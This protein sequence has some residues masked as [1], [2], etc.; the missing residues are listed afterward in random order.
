MLLVEKFFE[1]FCFVSVPNERFKSD[2]VLGYSSG[3][4]GF[5]YGNPFFLVII[6]VITKLNKNME[7][8]I[9]IPYPS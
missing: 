5:F 3:S 4:V 6:F 2:S 1:M 9:T 8:V 7:F